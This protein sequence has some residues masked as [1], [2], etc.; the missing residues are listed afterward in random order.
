MTGGWGAKR[1]VLLASTV[2]G[3]MTTLLIDLA[4]FLASALIAVPLSVRLGFSAPFSAIW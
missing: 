3:R 1:S 4:I 2:E